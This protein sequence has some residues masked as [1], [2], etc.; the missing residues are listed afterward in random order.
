M[1]VL[2]VAGTSIASWLAGTFYSLH[3]G[4]T[5]CDVDTSP[6]GASSS[7]EFFRRGETVVSG[8]RL[9]V[10]VILSLL[11]GLL[12]PHPSVHIGFREPIG[13]LL[14]SLPELRGEMPPQVIG[15]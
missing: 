4:V 3:S 13:G 12:G 1:S 10:R 11:L 15:G 7:S 2:L 9:I 8:R 6:H 5:T 14:F